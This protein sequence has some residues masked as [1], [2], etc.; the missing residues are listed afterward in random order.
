MQILN[1]EK[2]RTTKLIYC[3]FLLAAGITAVSCKKQLNVGNPNAPTLQGNVS[4]EKGIIALAKGGVYING[5]A[6]GDGWLG[7]SYFSLPW[8]YIELMGDMV[9]AE[10]SNNQVTTIG[11]PDYIILD[12]GSKLTN[13]APQVNIIRAYN[14]RA[15]TGADNNPLYYQWLNMY[16]LN[17]ACNLVLSQVD[18]IAFSGDATSRANTV[19]AWCYWW[20]GY[21]YASIGTMYYSGLATDTVYQTNKN[22]LLHDAIIEHSNEYLNKAADVIKSISSTSDY[23]ETLGNLI[24]AF[25][26]VGNGGVLSK[27]MWLR[28]INSMLARNILLNKL[29]PFVNGNL[30]AT[31]SKSSTTP[32]TA[33]DWNKVL[34]LT[35]AGIKNGDL[36]FTGRTAS[37]NGFFSANGGSVAALCAGLNQSN[38]FKIS[39]R[40]MQNFKPGDKRVD[41]NFNTNTAF[42]NDYTF[43]TRYNLVDGGNGISGVYTLSSKSVGEY[44]L[45][46]GPSYEENALMQAEADIRTGKVEDGL[47]LIDAVRKYQGAGVAAVAGTGLTAAKAMQELVMERKVSLVFRGL[48]F[49]DNRRWGWIYDISVGGGAYNQHIY[50]SSTKYLNTK[51]TI[52]Y[53]FMDYWDVPAD[54][55]VLNAPADGSAGATN[56]NY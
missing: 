20:K 34:T 30:N 26:Q 3:A 4:D 16:A 28:N 53:N 50:N 12:D 52:N 17:N 49:Y 14:N 44:E 43:A 10:A 55:S 40:Y 46:I 56:P 48:S 18:N 25:C 2:M 29:A 21:A 33:E 38:T 27:D 41:N 1:N 13:S 23:E 39:E 45:Y 5:F 54:E 22:Y 8:G 15:S 11:V 47:A 35:A 7:D 42:K 6:N 36:V 51:A 31:I 37:A 9:G 24:P 19:K 32:M